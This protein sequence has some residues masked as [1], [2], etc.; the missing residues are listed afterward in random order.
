MIHFHA[1]A[2]IK[3]SAK[4]INDDRPDTLKLFEQAAALVPMGAWSCDLPSDELAWT[5]G[6]FD[7]FGLSP[8]DI[9]DRRMV[10]G[11]YDEESR[12]LL[13]HKRSKAVEAC[14]DFT[15]DARIVRPD[16]MARWIRITAATRACNGRAEALYGMKQD[17][18]EDHARWERLRLQ[19]ECDPL[20]GVANRARFQR[21]LEQPDTS[22]MSERVGALLLFDLDGFKKINDWWGHAAGDACLAAF[23]ER[24]RRAFPQAHLISRIGGDEFAV[25]LPPAGMRSIIEAEVHAVIGNLLLPVPWG[26]DLLPLGV[27]VGFAHVPTEHPFDPQALFVSADKALYAAKRNPSLALVCA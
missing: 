3:D 11:M 19:A 21:F 23:A 17:I 9:L 22:A 1:N 14:S 8:K 24:L 10:L 18:T 20:T 26:G 2:A 25:L 5:G 7:L 15:L 4:A 13:E 27:S 6:V 12:E 16:G